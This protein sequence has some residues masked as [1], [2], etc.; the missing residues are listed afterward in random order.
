MLEALVLDHFACIYLL[1]NWSAKLFY[2]SSQD[3]ILVSSFK[4]IFFYFCFVFLQKQ[5]TLKSIWLTL[6]SNPFPFL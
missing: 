2:L 6:A 3:A 1:K 5:A 4:L